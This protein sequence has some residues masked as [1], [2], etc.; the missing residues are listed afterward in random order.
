MSLAEKQRKERLGAF[1]A[2][3]YGETTWSQ[4]VRRSTLVELCL[5]R[6]RPGLTVHRSSRGRRED[7][8][9]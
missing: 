2:E 8:P 9:S 4:V 3:S 1:H 7:N 6:F 5:R